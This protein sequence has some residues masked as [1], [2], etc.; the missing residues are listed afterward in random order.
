M[1]RINFMLKPYA[2]NVILFIFL[3]PNIAEQ[4]PV[5]GDLLIISAEK[6][7]YDV[8]VT[9]CR[10]SGSSSTSCGFSEPQMFGLSSC[11]S[12]WTNLT[13]L[14]LNS[15]FFMQNSTQRSAINVKFLPTLASSCC[16]L[17]VNTST[18]RICIRRSRGGSFGL[19]EHSYRGFCKILH[20]KVQ[21]QLQ[22]QYF[23]LIAVSE[24]E[25]FCP[26]N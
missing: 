17:F 10:S 19:I 23:S 14:T 3:K 7:A 5:P 12:F 13:L 11:I 4:G 9:R 24:H 25:F 26:I 22:R 21:V 16:W 6:W 2:V 1:A 20:K 15:E 8:T 18:K